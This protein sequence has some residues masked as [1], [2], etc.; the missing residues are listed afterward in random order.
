MAKKSAV[1][2]NLKRQR[3]AQRFAAKRE[4]LKAIA[5]DT[6]KPVEERFA[7]QLKLASLPRNS[8]PSRIR[9]RC[10]VTGRP[11]AY[12]RKLKMSRIALR[13]LA[14]HGLIPGMVKSSW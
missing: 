3:L 12:Y 11:R 10:Q 6:D 7:A 2:R 1:E 9:N 13:Q 4:A 8:A 14:S 5:R